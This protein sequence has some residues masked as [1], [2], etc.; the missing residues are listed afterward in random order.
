MS[1]GSWMGGTPA[2]YVPT[3]TFID[4]LAES[5]GADLVGYGAGTVED[6]LDSINLEIGGVV[7]GLAAS[8]GSAL[9]GFMPAGTGAV[10]RTVQD[11]HREYVSAKDFGAVGNGVADDTAALNA[12]LLVAKRGHIPP[13]T[14]KITGP[15]IFQSDQVI[16]GDGAATLIVYAAAVP[17]ANPVLNITTK[18][19]VF[20]SDFS[21][22]VSTTTYP[23]A[24]CIYIE[25][26]TNCHVSQIVFSGG[27]GGEAAMLL[28]THRC[29]VSKC[30]VDYYRSNGLYVNGGYGNVFDDNDLPDGSG[31]LMGIQMVNGDSNIA[32]NNRVA[33][34]TDLHFGIQ[35]YGGSFPVITGNSIKNTFREAIALGGS[36]FGARI[37]NN[38]CYWD[39]S[40]GTGDFGMSVAGDDASTIVSDFLIADNTIINSSYDAIGIAGW[41]KRG[42]VVNNMIRD[43]ARA[44]LATHQSG[45]KVYGWLAGA[46]AEDITVEGNTIAKVDSTGLLYAVSESAGLGSV[47]GNIIGDN[48]SFGLTGA[49]YQVSSAARVVLN[50][51]D[52][53]LI[54]HSA[55]PTPQSGAITTSTGLMQYQRVGRFMLCRLTIGI[56][57][58]GTG[59]G[60]LLFALPFTASAGV[61]SGAEVAVNG[62][63]C[64]A[65]P[66]GASLT[67]MNYDNTYP[68]A[69]GVSLV[70]TGILEVA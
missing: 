65:A 25:S 64:K 34:T 66:S 29:S 46:M 19:N 12:F 28:G 38:T 36:Q 21:M 26:S 13:G 41:C 51:Q 69:N 54:S 33:K 67:I 10:A 68:G 27:A 55:T 1:S 59:A 40:L 62:K 44:S 18:S 70:L 2:T 11:K 16:T 53:N 23:A 9:V 30:Y 22:Q 7:T 48:K 43:S 17:G 20:V 6:E 14:Y 61:L 5:T 56:T 50:S 37:T 35:A 58:N 52:L 63:A 3:P 31:G 49:M 60:A 32:R 24:R 47:S 8:G 4:R 15:L 42:R 45:I 57:T 39:T